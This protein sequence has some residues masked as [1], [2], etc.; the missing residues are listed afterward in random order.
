[1][2]V[3]AA[4]QQEVEEQAFTREQFCR[5]NNI[6]LSTLHELNKTGRGPRVMKVGRNAVRITLAAEA[7]WQRAREKEYASA[8]ERLER[9]R[10]SARMSQLGKVGARSPLH[11][12]RRRKKTSQ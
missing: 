7:A 5:R 3:A 8:A 12:C 1:M 10:V 2:T 11:P 4:Q 9:E 6:S